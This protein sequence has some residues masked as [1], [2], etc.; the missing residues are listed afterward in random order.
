MKVKES[1]LFKE[2]IAAANHCG[3][4]VYRNNQGAFRDSRG[5]WVRYGV[6]NGG[7]DLLGY[8]RDGRF[9]ALEIKVPN[10][11]PSGQKENERYDRQLDF[12]QAVVQAGGIGG[13]VH[14]Y[15]DVKALLS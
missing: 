10:W 2:C 7:S 1:S 14:G 9:L 12:I 3:A 15:E 8:T 13:I 5:Q 6:G 4:T 11:K